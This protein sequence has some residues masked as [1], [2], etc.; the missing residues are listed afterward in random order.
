MN[1]TFLI[2]LMFLLFVTSTFAASVSRDTEDIG[3]TGTDYVVHLRITDAV[4]GT[5]LAVAERLPE[6][7]TFVTSSVQGAREPEDGVPPLIDGKDTVWV[8]TAAVQDPVIT[9]TVHLPPVGSSARLDGVYG[10]APADFGRLRSRLLLAPLTPGVEI[11]TGPT[12]QRPAPTGFPIGALIFVLSGVAIAGVCAWVLGEI[13]MDA[14]REGGWRSGLQL[15]LL[16]SS[17][18]LKMLVADDDEDGPSLLHEDIR[19]VRFE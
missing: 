4:P 8:F 6:G 5:R 13:D 14:V 3:Y 2:A 10:A 9:Y 7:V 18:R 16:A 19:S 15:L 17:A 1:R 11:A 12:S